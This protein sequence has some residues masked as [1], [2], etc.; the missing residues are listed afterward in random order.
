MHLDAAQSAQ[1][2]FGKDIDVSTPEG[3]L[4]IIPVGMTYLL[5][6]PF[7]WQLTTL[8]QMITLPEM[9]LWW[10][11]LPLLVLGHVRDSWPA[12][13]PHIFTHLLIER[14]KAIEDGP[15]HGD[16][17][18]DGRRLARYLRPFGMIAA[19]IRVGNEVRKGYCRE[20][21]EGAFAR[22]LVPQP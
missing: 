16:D 3:V 10:L 14:L 18:F 22:Y 2:G 19:T 17:K 15:W 1:S 6:A 12:T 7:P 13:E 20:D 5:L 4:T 11:S 21:A 9:I 8:R